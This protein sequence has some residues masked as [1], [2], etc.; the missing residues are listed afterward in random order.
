[1]RKR[2]LLI[3]VF[4][5]LLG[6]TSVFAKNSFDVTVK[7]DS[8]TLFSQE[9]LWATVRLKNLLKEHYIL[10]HFEAKN[11]GEGFSV[12]LKK[13]GNGLAFIEGD[14]AKAVEATESE[15]DTAAGSVTKETT[16]FENAF[17]DIYVSL[18]DRFGIL[19]NGEYAVQVSYT[20]ENG[21]TFESEEV[22]FKL[23]DLDE[24]KFDTIFKKINFTT[25]TLEFALMNYNIKKG[26]SAMFFKL[27]SL[28]EPDKVVLLRRLGEYAKGGK[29]DIK[30]AG[31]G[32]FGLI[33]QINNDNYRFVVINSN[34]K[35]LKDKFFDAVTL[36][37][38]EVSSSSEFILRIK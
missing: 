38:L 15:A 11:N 7:V 32:T 29:L 19:S 37:R 27:M 24:S 20:D 17:Y 5:I 36:P 33:Y 34:G 26:K 14:D 10:R 13:G 1:M 30:Q 3:V 9:S 18:N 16:L 12:K 23:T 35:I 4:F 31:N 8:D 22:T 2:V 21:D 25:R 28:E 6:I